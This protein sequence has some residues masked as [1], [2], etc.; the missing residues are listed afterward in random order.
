MRSFDDATQQR[1]LTLL[2]ERDIHD[3]LVRYCR[4][5][6]RCDREL[7]ASC[8]HEDAVDDHGN[9][10]TYGRD[11]A[12]TIT[13][14]VQPGP[15]TAMHF[16]GNVCIE[17]EGDEAFTESYL[18]AYRAF[19]RDGKNYT[20]VRAVRFVDR[21]ARRNGQWRISERVVADD[22]NRVDEVIEAMR[23][24]DQF[25]RGSKGPDDPVFAIRRG[26]VAREPGST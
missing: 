25:R 17:V 14:R 9:W 19:Q 18:L 6:D 16:M 5:V 12:D 26:R 4:G 22:W 21:F 3:V 2:D 24:T 23:E 1:L 11:A 13:A 8:Y 15:D 7:I 20:R 10:Q